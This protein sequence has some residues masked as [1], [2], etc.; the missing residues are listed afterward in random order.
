MPWLVPFGLSAHKEHRTPA[1]P[2]YMTSDLAPCRRFLVSQPKRL[3][4][5]A[6]A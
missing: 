2:G 1:A 3:S 5:H 4:P 6:S